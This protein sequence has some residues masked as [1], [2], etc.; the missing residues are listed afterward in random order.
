MMPAAII[1]LINVDRQS[2]VIKLGAVDCRLTV[3]WQPSDSCWYATLEF[4]P[5]QPRARARRLV[6]D[7]GLLSRLRARYV[8]GGDIVCRPIGNNEGDPGERPWGATHRLLY[9]EY[10]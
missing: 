5:G 6:N 4:P 9:E 10:V 3:W 1:D 8:L 2:L 7:A